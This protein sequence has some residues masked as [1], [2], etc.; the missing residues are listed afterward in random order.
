MSFICP[1][2]HSSGCQHS[3]LL[4]QGKLTPGNKSVVLLRDKEGK[5]SGW[6]H[7]Q[8]KWIQAQLSGSG[9]QLLNK[10]SA[11]EGQ[12]AIFAQGYLTSHFD[13]LELNAKGLGG[14]ETDLL[15][16]EMA[17][18]QLSY[19]AAGAGAPFLV[20]LIHNVLQKQGPNQF[21][22]L[23]M[24]LIQA[25]REVVRQELK[26]HECGKIKAS[27]RAATMHLQEY[28]SNGS[29]D[30][31]Q[32][33][34]V[35]I[36]SA[37][38]ALMEENYIPSGL[39]LPLFPVAAGLRLSILIEQSRLLD[40]DNRQAIRQALDEF[41]AFVDQSI[42]R[43]HQWSDQ[44][45]TS[46]KELWDGRLLGPGYEFMQGR[47]WISY[48]IKLTPNG[49]IGSGKSAQ[50]AFKASLIKTVHAFEGTSTE[51]VDTATVSKSQLLVQ[52][53]GASASH[54]LKAD[55]PLSKRKTQLMHD[56]SEAEV[57]LQSHR[58][59]EKGK[60]SAFIEKAVEAQSEWKTL[61]EKI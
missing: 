5:I 49:T 51:I 2:H 3:S 22:D 59:A 19:Y 8:Q 61:K 20:P 16:R 21:A 26:D 44:R 50:P 53:R 52:G 13:S 9:F 4:F 35:E 24:S 1:I 31:L 12:K 58:Q 41:I 30:P 39:A 33:A 25:M 29:P 38:S 43:L 55:H 14:N 23:C 57:L 47:Y 40:L 60:L 7:T 42:D 36:V 56:L 6:I 37:V 28:A 32:Q 48:E 17:A 11:L 10:L 34:S 15:L 27:I 54:S 18:A 46:A 45:F